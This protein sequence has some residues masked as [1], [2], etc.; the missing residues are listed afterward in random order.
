VGGWVGGE[1]PQINRVSPDGIGG[2]AG[3]EIKFEV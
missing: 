3:K 1:H 2:V